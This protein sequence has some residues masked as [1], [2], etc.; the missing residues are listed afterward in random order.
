MATKPTTYLVRPAGA[1]VT[2]RG[3]RFLDKSVADKIA[4]QMTAKY[5]KR[6]VVVKG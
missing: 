2:M 6:Y 1:K 4:A 3:K 5:K